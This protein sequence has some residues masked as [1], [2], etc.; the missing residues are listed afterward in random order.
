MSQESNKNIDYART[1]NVARVHNAAARENP[2][3]V[4]EA[5]PVSL[6]VFAGGLLATLI[7]GAFFGGNAFSAAVYSPRVPAYT[8]TPENEAPMDP[9]AVGEKIYK[10]A[11]VAC[12]Q[13]AGNGVAGQFP[14]LDGSEWVTGS[15]E[16]LITIVLYGLTGPVKVKG[17]EYNGV[18]PAHIDL[19]KGD[20]KLAGLFTYLRSGWSNKASA[21][22]PEAVAEVKKKHAGR[23]G[24]KSATVAE[25]EAIPNTQILS[26]PPVDA[27][28]APATK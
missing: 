4:A 26:K 6:W 13:P 28:A 3:H 22:T 5:K 24:T 16:R 7:G 8:G 10:N 19:V 2:H 25:L 9:R 17:G 27:P 12:H 14:P 15:D 18:M 20:A 23:T 11:C 1:L 21:V